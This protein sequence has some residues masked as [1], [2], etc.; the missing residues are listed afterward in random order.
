MPRYLVERFIPHAAELTAEELADI[1]RQSLRA[2]QELEA[3][4]QWIQSAITGDRMVCL[5]I[6][7]DEA[8]VREHARLSGLP[9]QRISRVSAVI[10]P[11]MD[12]LDRPDRSTKGGDS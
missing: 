1:A 12:A 8:I 2:Q 4:I 9:I 10:G 7:D 6:A 11:T 3:E 5:Y